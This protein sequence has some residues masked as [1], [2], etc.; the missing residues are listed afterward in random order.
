MHMCSVTRRA[1]E[2]PVHFGGFRI[3]WKEVRSSVVLSQLFGRMHVAIAPVNRKFDLKL[4]QDLVVKTEN[5][6]NQITSPQ[7][8]CYVVLRIFKKTMIK[9]AL[10]IRHTKA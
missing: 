3:L 1:H 5:R 10:T 6:N 4:V 2:N 8:T 7:F 9:L